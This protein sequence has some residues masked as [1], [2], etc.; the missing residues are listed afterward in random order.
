VGEYLEIGGSGAESVLDSCLNGNADS[1][2]IRKLSEACVTS[3]IPT[4]DLLCGH[5]RVSGRSESAVP[6]VR[7]VEEFQ[8]A[9]DHLE[10]VIAS[11]HVREAEPGGILQS[12]PTPGGAGSGVHAI[13]APLEPQNRSRIIIALEEARTDSLYKQAA[14]GHDDVR[15]TA[16]EVPGRIAFYRRAAIVCS[17][18]SALSGGLYLFVR[19]LLALGAETSTIVGALQYVGIAGAVELGV[20]SALLYY[21]YNRMSVG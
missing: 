7:A 5:E 12:R 18:F 21:R 16:G 2:D 15:V 4:I 1:D 20:V 3:S 11:S 6:D 17:L 19:A 8:K 9:L 14:Y 13:R 10:Y